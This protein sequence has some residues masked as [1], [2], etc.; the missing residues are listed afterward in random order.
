MASAWL[1]KQRIVDANP[2]FALALHTLG[3]D[4]PPRP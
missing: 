3:G 2:R 4:T 1:I